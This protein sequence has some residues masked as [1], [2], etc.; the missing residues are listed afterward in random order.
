MPSLKSIPP[1]VFLIVD[2]LD[3]VL[4]TADELAASTISLIAERPGDGVTEPGVDVK[5]F[6]NR[7][8]ALE[9]SLLSRALQARARAS[10]LRRVPPEMRLILTSFVSGTAILDEAVEELA[11]HRYA[12]F[13]TGSCHLAYLRSRGVIAPDRGTLQGLLH[14]EIGDE[15]LV[16]KRIPLGPLMDLAAQF[17]N[18]LCLCY[19]LFRSEASLSGDRDDL[20]PTSGADDTQTTRA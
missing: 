5:T 16:A 7:V 11:D 17:L 14:I 10:E 2:H 9:L 3:S 1:N 8:R 6:V 4:A 20:D 15:F 18:T 13:E 12:D 19:D